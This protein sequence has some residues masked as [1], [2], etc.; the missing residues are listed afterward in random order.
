MDQPKQRCGEEGPRGGHP[1]QGAA[2]T[3]AHLH[4]R[5]TPYPSNAAAF[6]VAAAAAAAALL[7]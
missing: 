1:N 2:V 3:P 7:R 6:D 4:L 5:T